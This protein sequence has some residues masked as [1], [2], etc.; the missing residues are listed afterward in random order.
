MEVIEVFNTIEFWFGL[1][2]GVAVNKLALKA[3]KSRFSALT[4]TTS[5][6]TDKET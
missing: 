1:T 5:E 2:T 3:V 6:S 4:G